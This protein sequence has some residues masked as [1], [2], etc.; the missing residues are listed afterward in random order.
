MAFTAAALSKLTG[1]SP[2]KQAA[3]HFGIAWERY[4]GIGVLELAGAGGV[5]LGFAVTAIGAAAAI[6]LPLLMIAAV[7]THRRAGD[8][9][10]QM[11]PAA[12]LGVISAVTAGL[13][14]A[15]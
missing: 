8:P 6:G 14:L 11:A 1:L 13:Y 5:L 10:A 3:D 9:P 2:M 15:H 7:S 12:V 4:R